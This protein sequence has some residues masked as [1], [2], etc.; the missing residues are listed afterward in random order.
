MVK[1]FA[2]EPVV[3]IG[4]DALIEL[5]LDGH[6]DFPVLIR[7]SVDGVSPVCRLY[8]SCDAADR[9]YRQLQAYCEDLSRLA[10]IRYVLPPQDVAQMQKEMADGI[11]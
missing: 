7:P 9:L 4:D 8:M 5:S 10:Y 1:S 2:T 11:G 3:F 6:D